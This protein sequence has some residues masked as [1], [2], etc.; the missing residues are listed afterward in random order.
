MSAIAARRE[1]ILSTIERTYSPLR[2]VALLALI[3]GGVIAFAAAGLDGLSPAE[4]AVAP[5][6]F[7]FAN[8]A[9]WALHRWVMHVPTR[10]RAVYDRHTLTHHA[11]FL[12]GRMAID[13][14]REL[15]YVLM[16]FFALPAMVVAVSPVIA[17]LA[18]LW[19]HDAARV[20][21]I[22][23]VGYYL[24]Y[25]VLHTAYHLP[26]TTAVGRSRLVRALRRHHAHHHDPRVMAETN[27]NIPF[28]IADWV[29]GTR[30]RAGAP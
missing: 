20:F 11:V 4:A 28:P 27:F 2:H 14:P 12:P 1:Q 6:A 25:E 26:E 30:G 7:L 15:R 23:A 17:A 16:P 10:L 18:L 29:L 24:L 22:V 3:G 9:E 8:F 19:S 13:A 5:V 21:L